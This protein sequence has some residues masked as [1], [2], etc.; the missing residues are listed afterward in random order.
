MD[1]IWYGIAHAAESIFKLL[2]HVGF[3]LNW[4]FGIVITIGVVFW[5]AYDSS[6]RNGGPNYMANKGE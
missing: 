5:L 1:A 3:S 6:V 4:V 2:P